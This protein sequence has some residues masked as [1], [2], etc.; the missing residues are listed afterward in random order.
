[1]IIYFKAEIIKVRQGLFMIQ[2]NYALQ[3]ICYF[4]LEG[5]Q[6]VSTPMVERLKLTIGMNEDTV[7]SIYYHSIVD[8]LI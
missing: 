1:M 7:D 4:N 8:K 3:V 6:F 2:Q 5:C